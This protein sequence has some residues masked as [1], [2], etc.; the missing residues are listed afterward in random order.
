MHKILAHIVRSGSPPSMVPA[1]KT[2]VGETTS[3]LETITETFKEYYKKLYKSSGPRDEGEM[4]TF[5]QDIDIPTLEE[6]DVEELER[7]ITI[8]EIKMAVSE[9]ANHKS[10]GPDGLPVEIYKQYGEVLFQ[11][12]LGVFN[13]AKEQGRLPTSMTE[14]TI[15]VLHKEGK[16]PLDPGSYRPISLLCADVKILAK[17]LA[18]RVKKVIHKIVHPDQTVFIPHRTTSMNIR[19]VLLNL[20]IPTVNRGSRAMLLL[21]VVKAFDSIEWEYLW[22]VLKE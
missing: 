1:I 4:D 2:L 10:P 16:D 19:R 13:W 15:I 20:Q 14:A 17:I 8:E 7:P 18:I 11:E 5:F 3:Q 22:R 6:M 9:M 21:D 12:L